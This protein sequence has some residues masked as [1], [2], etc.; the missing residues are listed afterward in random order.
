MRTS[1][2]Q[3]GLGFT[4]IEVTLVVSVLLGLISVT[5]IGASAYKS[6][7]NRAMC[8]QNI[9]N[10][11]KAVRAFSNLNQVNSG[12][13]V[14][15]LRTQI[16]SEEGFLPIEPTCPGNGEYT[17]LD[18]TIPPLGTLYL[19]CSIPSHTPKENTIW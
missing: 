3:T 9:A 18:D 5:F 16:Y 17:F 4:L 2:A 6:G 15:G 19:T 10:A 8:L 12:N 14:P 1:N 11:Q 13:E 7:T